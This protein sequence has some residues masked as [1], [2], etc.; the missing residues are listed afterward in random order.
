MYKEWRNVI[1]TNGKYQVSNHGD[2]RSTRSRGK[3]RFRELKPQ[4]STNGYLKV[5][6]VLDDGTYK[7]RTIHR[8]VAECFLPNPDNLEMVNH[9]DECVSNNHVD[10]LE[11]CSRSYN[12]LY[13][14]NLH[15]ERRK[16]FGNN[17]LDKKTGINTSPF[18]KKGVPHTR[19]EKII[20]ST[21]DGEVIAIYDSAIEAALKNNINGS[22]NILGACKRNARTDRIRKRTKKSS[23][24]G[25]VW[26]FFEE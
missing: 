2:V 14:L 7:Q 26:E 12:Q 17:F 19:K 1:G 11:W 9:K 20:Q 6:L 4:K 16:V 10:N 8:M 24:Y 23:A 5:I 18:T 3:Q 25:Y 21:F 22:G 15:P 13:S